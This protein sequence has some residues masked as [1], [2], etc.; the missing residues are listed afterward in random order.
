MRTAY[1]EGM[2][3][4][5]CVIFL[6]NLHQSSRDAIKNYAIVKAS[7]KR[8]WR[9][10]NGAIVFHCNVNRCA[11]ELQMYSESRLKIGTGVFA[12]YCDSGRN[13]ILSVWLAL[14]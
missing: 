9:R 3:I 12:Y 5:K 7:R 1:V 14:I 6:P 8:H 2:L 10:L 11:A 13:T 4:L